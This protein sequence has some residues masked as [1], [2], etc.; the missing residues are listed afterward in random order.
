MT[1]RPRRDVIASALAWTALFTTLLLVSLAALTGEP[2]TACALAVAA[3][4]VGVPVVAEGPA[5]PRVRALIAFTTAGIL[6]LL[7]GKYLWT[8]VLLLMG[9]G[10]LILA[11]RPEGY[12]A[13]SRLRERLGTVLTRLLFS[14]AAAV[15]LV[16]YWFHHYL[17]TGGGGLLTNTDPKSADLQLLAAIAATAAAVGALAWLQDQ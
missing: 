14:L 4:S 5:Q 10:V 8:A 12:P 7:Y 6:L 15:A 9:A 16:T 3:A 1:R 11:R 2:L 13:P 17:T